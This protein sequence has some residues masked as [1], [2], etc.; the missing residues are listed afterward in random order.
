MA[1][2]GTTEGAGSLTPPAAACQANGLRKVRQWILSDPVHLEHEVD[3]R[4]GRC[5]S[6]ADRAD[7]VAFGDRVSRRDPRHLGHMP[8]ER[9]E[10]VAV[11]NLHVI[12][13]TALAPAR[14]LDSSPV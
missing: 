10:P 7:D 9:L 1:W 11:V 5:S 14:V 13:E 2:S 12:A 8:I 3:V 6:A 4:S